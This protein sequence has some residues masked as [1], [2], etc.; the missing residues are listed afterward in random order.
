M[1][2]RTL[3]SGDTREVPLTVGPDARKAKVKTG[4]GKAKHHGRCG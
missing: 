4:V 3:S 1:V 2:P